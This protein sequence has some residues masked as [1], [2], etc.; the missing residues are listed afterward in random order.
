[1]NQLFD[2]ILTDCMRMTAF[3]AE[4]V[5]DILIKNDRKITGKTVTDLQD[6]FCTL[7]DLE[8]PEHL[9]ND[10]AWENHLVKNYSYTD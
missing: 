4:R 8:A 6:Y 3:R 10:K 7:V 2:D 1:M 5:D 9:I